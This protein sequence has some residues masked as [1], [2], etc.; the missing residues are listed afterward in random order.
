MTLYNTNVT[1]TAHV[2][3]H[4]QIAQLNARL[5]QVSASEAS[6]KKDSRDLKQQ[7]SRVNQQKQILAK[8][9]EMYEAD[10]RELEHEV[11]T[12]YTFYQERVYSH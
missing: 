11:Q 1:I 5:E 10:K 8:T 4:I 6:I 2:L 7:L 12:Y 3:P 9:T